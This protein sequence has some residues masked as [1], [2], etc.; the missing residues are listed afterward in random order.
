MR[1][2]AGQRGQQRKARQQ[3]VAGHARRGHQAARAHREARAERVRG[4]P[5]R[6]V[7]HQGGG[8]QQH[9]QLPARRRAEPREAAPDAGRV[10]GQRRGADQRAAA[11]QQPQPGPGAAQGPGDGVRT[12]TPPAQ[13]QPRS[14]PPAAAQQLGQHLDAG[15]AAPRP[16]PAARGADREEHEVPDAGRGHPQRPPGRVDDGERGQGQV[17][18]EDPAGHA[19]RGSRVHRVGRLPRRAVERTAAAPGTGRASARRTPVVAGP[20]VLAL[21]LRL[22]RTQCRH[23]G[24]RGTPEEQPRRER[25][26]QQRSEGHRLGGTG[27]RGDTDEFGALGEQPEPGGDVQGADQAVVGERRPDPQQQHRGGDTGEGEAGGGA[28]R[29]ERRDP[30]RRPA[31]S[32]AGPGPPARHPE[33]EPGPPGRARRASG[34]RNGITRMRHG[35]PWCQKRPFHSCKRRMVA[36]STILRHMRFL[37]GPAVPSV[38]LGLPALSGPPA[39]SCQQPGTACGRPRP[40]G[41]P[42]RPRSTGRAGLPYPCWSVGR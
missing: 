41:R 23:H 10:P 31:R 30:H 33:G 20:A 9:G 17:A 34:G 13:Q 28:A 24:G 5:H 40:V 15:P 32:G 18:R 1:A 7:G 6:E 35:A 8:Q 29:R 12:G 37:Y 3:P 14:G 22:R 21:L 25:G 27:E 11:D 4:R 26:E 42:P 39:P 38:P 16:G 36:V 2:L 19:R